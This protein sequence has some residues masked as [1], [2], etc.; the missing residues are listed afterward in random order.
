LNHSAY[1]LAWPRIDHHVSGLIILTISHTQY[2][3]LVAFARVIHLANTINSLTH[4]TKGTLSLFLIEQALTAY[5]IASSGSISLVIDSLFPSHLCRCATDS[6]MRW[7]KPPRPRA[8]A[9]S[10]GHRHH[11]EV[12]LLFSALWEEGDA[13]KQ[14]PLVGDRGRELS[15]RVVD[16]MWDPVNSFLKSHNYLTKRLSAFSQP[17]ARSS[18]STAQSPQQLFQKPQ[19][20]QIHPKYVTSAVL[21][22]FKCPILQQ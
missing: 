15:D 19:L 17:T 3:E 22:V 7:C 9:C 13:D 20:N 11:P 16:D 2:Y 6:S 8:Q 4:Y 14:G 18:F 10:A 1:L 21:M 12:S 5:M